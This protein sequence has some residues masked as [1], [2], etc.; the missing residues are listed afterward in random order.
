MDRLFS[1]LENMRERPE[2]AR[3]TFAMII[4]FG[5]TLI[6]LML[7]LVFLFP[8]ALQVADKRA[9]EQKTALPNQPNPTNQDT[10]Q[11]KDWNQVWSEMQDKYGV[12]ASG[13]GTNNPTETNTSAENTTSVAPSNGPTGT[14]AGT[15]PSDDD[16]PPPP[17]ATPGGF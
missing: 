12:P 16:V 14:G 15:A 10:T 7:W 11:S 2:H 6:L 13:T 8:H 9:A 1:F 4:A 3:R 5:V 17:G